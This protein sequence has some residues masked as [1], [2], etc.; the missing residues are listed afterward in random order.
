MMKRNEQGIALV[1]TLF[2]MASLSALAVSLMFLAQTETASSRN[3]R[4]MS[5]ARY[6]GEAG[7]HRV[8]NYVVTTYPI[9]SSATLANFDYTKSPV[10]CVSG[11]THI[12]S[13]GA[14]CN[15]STPAL[16]S[17]TGCVV[18]S[19]VS[20][21]TNYPDA[22]VT[23]AFPAA[24]S[25]TL[26]VNSSGS[27][28]NAA[29]GTVTYSAT[30]VLM[31]LRTLNSYGAGTS[32]VEGWKVLS[33]GTVPGSTPAT[34]EVTSAFEQQYGDA[35]TFAVFATGTGCGAINLGGT[36]VTQSFDGTNT[37]NTGGNVGT[38]GNMTIGG[39]VDV[40]G[41]LSSPR[42]GVG[43]CQTGSVT[44][45]TESGSASVDNNALVQLPAALSFATPAVPA[46]YTG[47]YTSLNSVSQV[48]AAVTLPATCSTSGNGSNAIATI[49]PMGTTVNLGNVS[50]N[51]VLMGGNYN[52]NSIGNV[53]ITTGTSFTGSSTVVVNLAG[54]ASTDTATQQTLANP[55]SVTSQSIQNPSMDASKFQVLYG[56]T[57]QID[58]TGGATTSIMLYAPNASVVTHGNSAI[59]GSLL[60][61]QV[62]SQGTPNFI[63][64]TRLKKKF[65]T[66]G[67]WEMTAFS[68]KKY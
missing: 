24:G 42:K 48:C 9:P 66:V 19:G 30:A 49:D 59:Y 40:H 5:Q 3:Y 58:M 39:H 16:A 13:A 45:L 33:D 11:C 12:A 7:V 1:I 29:A 8:I 62:T 57:G 61:A 17:S 15:A 41:S 53:N 2:L 34:V 28:T 60:A 10:T 64:D 26:A 37:Y 23:A 31:S 51:L 25:G 68:W 4:T 47:E 27:T 21:L 55:F 52:I 6:A 50:A 35:E 65:F 38:N 56:G 54:R 32:V 14:S 63:Y 46:I 36:V 20:G 18:L 43:T 22:T 67:G 44:A